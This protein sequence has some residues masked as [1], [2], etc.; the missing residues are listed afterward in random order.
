MK[1]IKKLLLLLPI[2]SLALITSCGENDN[3]NNNQIEKE[4]YSIDFVVN[5]ITI[6]NIK[7]KE[8]NAIKLPNEPNITGYTFEGWFLD[9]EFKNKLPDNYIPNGNI[10]IYGKATPIEKEIT[11]TFVADTTST[12]KI[13]ANSKVVEPKVPIKEGYTFDGWYLNNSSKKFNFDTIITDNMTLYAKFTINEYTVSFNTFS[14]STIESKTVKYNKT[15]TAPT[16]PT[17]EGYIFDGWYSDENFV[18]KFNFNTPITSN[19]TLYAKWNALQFNVTFNTNGGNT[20]NPLVVDYNTVLNSLEVPTKKGYT[21]EG[22]YTNSRLTSKYNHTPLTANITL[23]AKWKINEYTVSFNVNGN[24]TTQKVNYNQ[25]VTKP[26]DP[27]ITN[28]NFAG[29]YTDNT[30]NT[31]FNFDTLITAN[32]TLYA[33]IST[34]PIATFYVDNAIYDYVEADSNN[35]ILKPTDPTK[36]GYT[37]INWYKEST[38]TNVFNF[39]EAISD[40]INLYAKFEINTYTVT[41]NNDGN[42]TTQEIDYNQKAVKPNNP[43]KEHYDFIGWYLDN[44]TTEFN[45]NTPITANITL[46]AKYTLSKYTVTFNVN[47]GSLVQNQQI[48]YNKLAN[49]VTTTKQHYTFEGWYTDS[50]LTNEFNFTTPITENITL[51][52]KWVE[53]NKYTIT[54]ITDDVTYLT[55]T[56]YENELLTKPANPTKDDLSFEGWYTDSSL[57]TKYDFTEPVTE[58]FSLYAKFIETPFTVTN[59]GGY[60]EGAY[61]EFELLPASNVSNYKVSYKKS[62]DS[63]YT[64]IDSNLIRLIDTTTVRADILGLSK[65]TYSIKI[66]TT[67]ISTKIEA[68]VNNISVSENDR[69]GYAHFN[70]LT[71][72]GGYNNDGTV[73]SNAQIVYVSEENKNTVQCVIGSKTYTGISAI[74]QAQKN[75]SNPLII[76]I[77]GTVSAATWN[78]ID[79]KTTSTTQITPDKVIGS[80]GKALSLKNYTEEEIIS[81]GFN[82]LNTS[83]YS[84]LNGLTNRIK[85]DSSK[86]EFDS[87]YNMLDV[88]SAK[89]VT[90]EGVGTDATLFQWGIT[91]KSCQSIEVRNLTF[92]DYT[93]DACSFEGGSSE[94]TESLSNFTSKYY[95][96]HNNTFNLGVNYWDVCNEQDKHEGDGCTDFKYVANV[97][98]SYNHY[99]KTHK[100]GLVGGGDTHHSA[101]FTFHHNFYDQCQS[102]LPF[103]RQAN[104]HM[105]NNYYYGSTGTN[106]QI[107]AGAYAFIENCYFEKVKN[108]MV[109]KTGGESTSLGFVNRIGAA[110]LYN[111]VFN[112]CS[113][114]NNGTVVSSRT[115]AV[116]NENCYNQTFDTDSSVFYYDST[117]QKSKVTLLT[118]P[119]QAKIDCQKY[120]GALTK[121]MTTPSTD[122]TGGKIETKTFTITFNTNTTDVEKEPLTVVEGNS[123][124]L[125]SLERTGYT[126]G[127]WY[128]DSSLT[129]KANDEFIPTANTTLYAKWTEKSNVSGIIADDIDVGISYNSG[130]KIYDGDS[131]SVT[132]TGINPKI[133]KN[134]SNAVAND[135]SNLTFTTAFLPG[136]TTNSGS[137]GYTITA[138]TTSIVSIYF[139]ITDSK[140]TISDQ[141]KSGELRINSSIV[142]T[143]SGSKSNKIA[144]AYKLNITQGQTYFVDS[145]SN[146]LAIF[147]IIEN[148]TTEANPTN[149][150]LNSI[151]LGFNQTELLSSGST[152]GNSVYYN[153]TIKRIYNLGESFNSSYLTVTKNSTIEGTTADVILLSSE[154]TIDSSSFNK[155][156]E[157]TYTITVSV[158]IGDITKQESFKVSVVNTSISIINNIAQVKVDKTYTGIIGAIVDNYNMFTSIEEALEYLELNTS[159]AQEKYLLIADGLY[160]EKLEINIPN[161][162]ICGTSKDNT[163]IEWNSLYGIKDESGFEQVTD[164]T[165]TVAIRY[166]ATNVTIKNLTI[167]NYWNSVDVFNQA[168]GANYNE[169]RAL[170]LLVQT[171]KFIMDNCKLL[172]YQDTLELMTGRQIIKNTYISGTTDFIFG[173]NNTTYFYR[174]EI[175]SISTGKTDGG[176]IT[177]FKG[178]NK[179]ESDYIE[180]GAIFNECN[181]TADSDVI[182][183]GNTAIARPWN[184]YSSVMIMNSTLAGHIS[185]KGYTDGTTK[186]Q[187]YVKMSSVAPNLNTI[188]FYEYNNTGAGAISTSVTGC[189]V[190]TDAT[191]ASNYS[192][193]SKIFGVTN[194]ALK[195]YSQPWNGD[196]NEVIADES[197]Y[198]FF[199]GEES[200]TGTSYTYTQAIENSST[201]I[202]WNGLSINTSSNGK[203]AYNTAGYTQFNTNTTITLTVKGGYSFTI[204]SYPG[205]HNYTVNNVAVT[206]DEYTINCTEETTIVVKATSTSYIYSI[207]LRKI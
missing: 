153:H 154:Y 36:T 61:V 38:L 10:T 57:T 11:I 68:Y 118:T 60:N 87:Y 204:S 35:K 76:R 113:G 170:A 115:K 23:Y 117:N 13:K 41:F 96:V 86:K 6:N 97:T 180:Y 15:I 169:H 109:M 103:A 138:K 44:S 71:G 100:T 198:Y 81:G 177:A 197:I 195:F 31:L 49:E 64:Q 147:A 48:E 62:T 94:N 134:Y 5:G 12:V 66:E 28:G 37:F 157:G 186:N 142:T 173:T 95:W 200:S 20:I 141:S 47:G 45:F 121:N 156:V 201:I 98:I 132:A 120:A 42:I 39:N 46:Y 144:Y 119:E 70:N 22:W 125:P 178:S 124:T 167:S 59:N 40:N 54:F 127:G 135:S 107:Y 175:H 16:A 165:Q 34:K 133:S 122:I 83:Q 56:V 27:S 79:Y 74:L 8:G 1:I 189:T 159:S 128:L 112:G 9:Q 143:V 207:I 67:G 172:G 52:A 202:E 163:I 203:L 193:Y 26:T 136:G 184:I 99:Y 110:K 129:T 43:S 50:S 89:N 24:I 171:D 51:Y 32:I 102:R 151:S 80:N 19:T 181:F 88:S 146:R 90:V 4:E 179:G 17:K 192:D 25:K 160:N 131:F 174:C 182:S 194:G 111:N 116:T 126:F 78:K 176:F 152:A 3:P 150:I 162:T 188:K 91:W 55:T 2:F 14:E 77:I 187:R 18:N 145:S 65:G 58:G 105:Y 158:T 7:V 155:D 82:T 63:S 75:N 185:T 164:S 33:K 161:L 29:W 69:S 140:F 30:Y 84:K 53:N 149:E 85:Y 139:T 130:S 104:M 137:V 206:A 108:P 93:E 166:K 123:I 106:M 190:I 199:N 183:A 92:N 21:F 205:Q 72:V 191:L 168:F 101:N 196:S 73:K 148:N 114:T